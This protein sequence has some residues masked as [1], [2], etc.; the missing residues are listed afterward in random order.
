MKDGSYDGSLIDSYR[1]L[2]A[3]LLVH[4]MVSDESTEPAIED[5]SANIPEEFNQKLND[6]QRWQHIDHHNFGLFDPENPH[7]FAESCEHF[8]CRK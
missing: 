2:V 8:G 6:I 5:F 4:S 3:C 1:H 7:G